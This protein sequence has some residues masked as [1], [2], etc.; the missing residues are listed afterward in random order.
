LPRQKI[1]EPLRVYL[2]VRPP[3]AEKEQGEPGAEPCIAIT[4]D[5]CIELKPPPE[6]SS[7]K[8]G[9][10]VSKLSFSKVRRVP[11]TDL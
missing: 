4:S 6:S 11:I 10:A 9:E 1:G 8:S 3:L 5:D 7:A 2:R